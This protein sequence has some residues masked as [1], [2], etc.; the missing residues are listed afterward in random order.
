MAPP[1]SVLWHTVVSSQ[2]DGKL[3]IWPMLI[4]LNSLETT[5]VTG[6]LLLV[7]PVRRL[8]TLGDVRIVLRLSRVLADFFLCAGDD[9]PRTLL[10]NQFVAIMATGRDRPI[11]DESGRDLQGRVHVT[12]STPGA[13]VILG[14]AELYDLDNKCVPDVL[15]LRARRPDTLVVSTMSTS[16]TWRTRVRRMLQ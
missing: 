14:S 8:A 15:G 5:L 1:I 9:A 4:W 7:T 10:V 11:A 3:Y 12:W 2:S 13:G 6:S 16:L